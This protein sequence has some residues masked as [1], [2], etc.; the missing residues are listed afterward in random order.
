LGH[1][2]CLLNF[3]VWGSLGREGFLVHDLGQDGFGD[4]AG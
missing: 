3:G 2:Q 4:T 1:W